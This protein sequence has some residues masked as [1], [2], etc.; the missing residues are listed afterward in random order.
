[1]AY[2]ESIPPLRGK[3][4]KEFLRRLEA[5]KLTPEQQALFKDCRKFYRQLAPQDEDKWTAEGKLVSHDGI[6]SLEGRDGKV[7]TLRSWMLFMLNK[8][9]QITME[10]IKT[11]P[12]KRKP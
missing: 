8:D 2:P 5:F 12:P 7:A 9:V 10:P 11:H 3:A 4:A 1:M 6:L